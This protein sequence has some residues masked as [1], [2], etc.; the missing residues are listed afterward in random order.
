MP[1]LVI[2]SA[3][4]LALAVDRMNQS[5]FPLTL[6]FS[7]G[8]PTRRDRQNRLAQRWYG[9]VSK[10]LGDMSH[11]EARAMCKLHF[12]VPILRAE[13][14]AFAASYDRVMLKLDYET[15]LEAI[16]AWD[17]PVTRLMG[18]KQMTRFMDDMSKYWTAQGVMLTDPEAL[19]WE[20]YQ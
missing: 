8:E 10:Q 4:G 5:G 16:R 19:K 6:S 11:D 15:K 12:G 17:M 20:S 14:D 13:N 9:D 2:R 1:T 3:A 18:V 7:E